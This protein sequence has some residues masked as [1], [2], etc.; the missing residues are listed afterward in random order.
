M[1]AVAYAGDLPDL[2]DTF[3]YKELAHDCRPVDLA[4]WS[5]P[6]KQVLGKNHVQLNAL[7]LC[8]SARYPIFHVNFRYDPMG[9]TDSF[10]VPF[11]NAMFSANS[12]NPMAFVET[13]SGNVIVMISNDHGRPK[14]SYEQYRPQSPN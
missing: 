14:A 12:H 11:Y 13:T 10:F 7:E 4:T 8:N 5:Y 6:T 2:P 9:P 1:R 3:L